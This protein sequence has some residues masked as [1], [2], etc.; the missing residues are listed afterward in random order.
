MDMPNNITVMPW[1]KKKKDYSNH[2][3]ELQINNN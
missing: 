1:K 2:G 3:D